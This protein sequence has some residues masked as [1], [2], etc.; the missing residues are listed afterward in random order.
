[1]VKI[2][3]F[4]FCFRNFVI[5]I[6]LP[7]DCVIYAPYPLKPIEISTKSDTADRRAIKNKAKCAIAV[8]A[9]LVAVYT[10]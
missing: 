2:G 8:I 4:L 3:L 10:P 1:M 6:F 9:S 7:S 5:V